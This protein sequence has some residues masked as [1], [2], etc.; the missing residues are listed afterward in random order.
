MPRGVVEV[1]DMA[2]RVVRRG[3]I[4]ESS[5]VILPDSFRRYDVRL[6]T[7]G[8]GLLPG[9]YRVA[10]SYRDDNEQAVKVAAQSVWYVGA[11]AVWLVILGAMLVGGLFG[12]LLWTRRLRLG[13]PQWLRR[14]RRGRKIRK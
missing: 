13:W 11:L 14:G 10:V 5:N 1:K 2:G 8:A 4:N 3:V 12:W 6:E 9:R 7:I